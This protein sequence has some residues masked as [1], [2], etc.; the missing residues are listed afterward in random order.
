MSNRDYSSILFTPEE[1]GVQTSAYL[2]QRKDNK[3][4]GV[5][6][7]LKCLDNP[8]KDGNFLLP[9]HPGELMGIIARPG[10]A[11][12]GFMV[13]WARHRASELRKA[14]V[15]D[16]AIVYITLEQSVEELNAFNVAAD[17]RLSITSMATGEITD[18]E[19]KAVL[20]ASVQRRFYPLWNVGY[21]AMTEKK[22]IRVDVDGIKG[23]LDLLRDKHEKKIDLIFVDYLQRVP[24]EHAESKTVG[25]SDVLDNLK[26]ICLTCKAPMIVGVQAKREVD[27]T[28]DKIPGLDDG[29]WTSNIEQTCDRV[30]SLVRPILYTNVGKEF[31][32]HLV[33]GANEILISVFKQKLGPANFAKWAFF[34]PEYNKLD[35]LEKNQ[36]QA[37]A[38]RPKG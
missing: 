30:I 38:Q 37:S 33:E 18:E 25:I 28:P 35:E 13:R 9:L 8:D 16:R 21:S 4:L 32:N 20:K 11:K 10:N 17:N 2:Q 12:T 24:Y 5:K 3:G 6:V 29:Q 14:Q 31:G 1:I 23:A 27:E 22:Q 36:N 7:G 15:T 26:N 34:Q 19:W